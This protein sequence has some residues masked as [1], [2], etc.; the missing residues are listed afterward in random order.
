MNAEW[1]FLTHLRDLGRETAETW[2]DAHF[3]DVG[4]RGTVD[5]RSMFAGIGPEH[6]G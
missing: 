1:D 6:Q 5:L 2:L 4:E 3:D